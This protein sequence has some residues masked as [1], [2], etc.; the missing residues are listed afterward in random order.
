MYLPPVELGQLPETQ[1]PGIGRGEVS[2]LSP[3]TVVKGVITDL[4]FY[5][6]IKVDI[7]YEHDALIPMEHTEFE[8]TITT[9]Q[10]EEMTVGQYLFGKLGAEIQVQVAHVNDPVRYRF[11]VVGGVTQGLDHV[12]PSLNGWESWQPRVILQENENL[13]EVLNQVGRDF[14][15]QRYVIGYNDVT[16]THLAWQQNMMDE[17][18]RDSN[19]GGGIKNEDLTPAQRQVLRVMEQVKTQKA[20]EKMFRRAR[21]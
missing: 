16:N 2:S 17:E 10:G 5:H 4:Y 9:S 14:T 6:G 15:P 1:H 8:E 19:S 21:R 11:P 3:G 13:S 12:G 7:G 18:D 20:A